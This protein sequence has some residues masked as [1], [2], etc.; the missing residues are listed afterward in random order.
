MQSIKIHAK[1]LFFVSLSSFLLYKSLNSQNTLYC[2]SLGSSVPTYYQT[3]NNEQLQKKYQ[4]LTVVETKAI[5]MLMGMIRDKDLDTLEFRILSRRLIKI[6]LEEALATECDAEIVK[7]SPLGYYKTIHNPRKMSD[8]LA[9]S[10]LR[11]GNSMTEDLIDIVPE[12]KIGNILVQRNESSATKEAVFFFE[13]LPK[14]VQSKRILLLDPMLATGGS[15]SVCIQKLLDKGVKEEN[16][17]FINI[18]A[19]EEGISTI[20]KKY[21]KIKLVTAKC[22]PEL[23]PNKYIA[24][25]LGDFGDRFYGTQH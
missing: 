3:V 23:L 19:C 7:Q 18:I 10:I 14:D 24:P 9:I 20:F 17:V 6:L 11:S 16:I 8:Y 25:G 22:D 1:K 5:Q 13:K 21:P 15:A 4:N 2:L 12:I